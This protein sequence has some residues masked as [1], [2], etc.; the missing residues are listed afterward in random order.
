MK[1]VFQKNVDK[2]GDCLAACVASIFELKLDDVPNFVHP[3]NSDRPNGY[4]WLQEL[5]HFCQRN[6]GCFA[7]N[8]YLVVPHSSWYNIAVIQWK[9]ERWH[10][11][12]VAKGAKLIHDPDPRDV[13]PP[14]PEEYI[15][16]Y[17]LG[18]GKIGH[19]NG[20]VSSKRS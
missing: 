20:V 5:N 9:R 7:F 3:N 4:S 10:H 11:A 1:R 14:Q 6:L 8:S 12:I 17:Y 18:F 2:N 13:P 15:L 19:N 16:K